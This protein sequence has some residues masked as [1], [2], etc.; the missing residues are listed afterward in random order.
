[1]KQFLIGAILLF[2]MSLS[3]ADEIDPNIALIQNSF[4]EYLK[5]F[6]ARDAAGLATHFQLP[7]INQL[8]TPNS[9]FH[10]KEELINFWQ[11]FPLQDGYSYSTSDSLKIQRLSGSIYYLDLDYSRYND[12][13]E[14][15][16]EGSSIY[17]Y[18]KETGSWKIFFQWTGD[19]E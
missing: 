2:S 12:S 15:L 16:Y 3:H 5:D 11:S 1:M 6:I 7:S 13:D 18:G 17:L 4:A 9:V 8:T 14:L 19:R 10:T